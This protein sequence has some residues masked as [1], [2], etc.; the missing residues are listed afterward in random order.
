M[1]I[2]VTGSGGFIGFHLSK[3]LLD[4]NHT[5]FGYDNMNSYYDVKLKEIELK[6]YQKAKNS[7]LLKVI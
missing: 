1:K 5:V 4:K 7:F 6:F 3:Y 2:L